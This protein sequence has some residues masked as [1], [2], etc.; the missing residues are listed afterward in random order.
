MRRIAS[1]RVERRSNIARVGGKL[2]SLNFARLSWG[3]EPL[4]E[5]HLLHHLRSRPHPPLSTI[6]AAVKTSSDHRWLSSSPP[7]SFLATPHSFGIVPLA[8]A[9]AASCISTADI[10]PAHRHVSLSLPP[11]LR[12]SRWHIL[13]PGYRRK[14]RI[15]EEIHNECFAHSITN[16]PA[17][18]TGS[19]GQ[20]AGESLFYA[21]PLRVRSGSPPLQSRVWMAGTSFSRT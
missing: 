14:R 15:D 5:P 19:W 20:F 1:R 2:E 12:P 16:W 6:R 9:F 13:G 21:F 3:E 10:P 8:S 11:A 7:L 17:E 18:E 4:F